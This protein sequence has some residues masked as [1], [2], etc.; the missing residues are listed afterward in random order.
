MHPFER[1]FSFNKGPVSKSGLQKGPLEDEELQC[2][3]LS[4]AGEVADKKK[5]KENP[6]DSTESSLFNA[7]L[8]YIFFFT[9]APDLEAGI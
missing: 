2:F 6:A 3:V 4:L 8:D 5:K 7:L 1:A 9:W